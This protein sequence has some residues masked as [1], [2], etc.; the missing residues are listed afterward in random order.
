MAATKL[1]PPAPPARLVER[2]RL[3]VILDDGIG[4]QVPLVLASAPAGSGK[5]TLLA[6]WA[7]RHPGDIAW[8]QV[9]DSDSDP[10]R[11]WASLVAAIGRSRPDFVSVVAPVVIG[12][13]GDDRVVVPRGRVDEVDDEPRLLARMTAGHAAHPLL[14][15]PLRGSRRQVHAHGRAG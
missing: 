10:A 15:D 3:D 6:S 12:S 14:V 4:I 9:E 13:Q 2:T 8:L 7:S 1:R 11:F 5:S